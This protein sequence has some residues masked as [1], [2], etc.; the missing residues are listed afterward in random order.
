MGAKASAEWQGGIRSG[1]GEFTAGDSISGGFTY[2]SRFEDGSGSNPEQLLG[3]AHASCFSMA[4]ASQLERAGSPAVRIHTDAEVT[5]RLMDGSPTI[6]KV[7]LVT[8][9]TVPGVD[10]VT[11]AEHAL[12]AKA[13]CPVSRA[14]AGVPEVNLVARLEGQ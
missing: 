13:N 4:L 1:T 5:I 3:A 8:V 11:F 2:R 14:L 6:T 9:G 10:E 12:S 7:D